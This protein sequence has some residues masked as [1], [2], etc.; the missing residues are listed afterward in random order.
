MAPELYEDPAYEDQ[1]VNQ[2]LMI[3]VARPQEGFGRLAI[4]LQKPCSGPDQPKRCSRRA[5]S[6]HTGLS[7]LTKL[8]LL[9]NLCCCRCCPFQPSGGRDIQCGLQ[10]RANRLAPPADMRPLTFLGK[11]VASRDCRLCVIS[12]LFR[13]NVW[14]PFCRQDYPLRALQSTPSLIQRVQGFSFL[15]LYSVHHSRPSQSKHTPIPSIF[16]SLKNRRKCC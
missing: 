11:T 9:L 3:P 10:S 6:F 16:P 7:V 15:P 13:P 2:P 14:F 4:S 12:E 5:G 8:L 1:K